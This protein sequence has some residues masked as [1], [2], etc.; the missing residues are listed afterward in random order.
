MDFALAHEDFDP[1]HLLPLASLNRRQ[2]IDLPGIDPRLVGKA[3][4]ELLTKPALIELVQSYGA[5]AGFEGIQPA[6]YAQRLNAILDLPDQPAYGT[7]V[8][9]AE[10]C[11]LRLGYLIASILL[12][13]NGLTQ[14][15]APWEA[16]YLEHWKRDVRD[17]YLGGGHANSR[18]G[19]II[20]R[21]AESTLLRCGIQ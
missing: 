3:A 18:L 21:V 11:G 6:E 4:S 15:L 7:A 9:I 5:I 14:P 2:I 8:Q 20:S 12:S 16:S 10:A 17:I 19:E 1:Y 13:P